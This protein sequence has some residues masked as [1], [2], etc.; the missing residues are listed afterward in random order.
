MELIEG[1]PLMDHFTSL[2]EKNE[3]F[4]EERIWKIFVQVRKYIVNYS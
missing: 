4:T 2:K 3:Y 1:A